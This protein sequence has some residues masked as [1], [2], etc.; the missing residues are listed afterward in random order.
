MCNFIIMNNTINLK[1]ACSIDPTVNSKMDRNLGDAFN[2]PLYKFFTKK[3][4]IRNSCYLNNIV[5][6][7]V[8]G[9]GSIINCNSVCDGDIVYGSGS[10]KEDHSVPINKKITFRSVRG[11][12]TRE[13]MLKYGYDCPPVYGDPGL[14][15]PFIYPLTPREKKYKIG[16]IPNYIDQDDT[17]LVKLK[18]HPDVLIINILCINAPEKF[19][20]DVNSCEY[21]FSSSL[22]GIIFGDAY[23]IPSYYMPLSDKVIGNGFKFKD[24]FLSV[25]RDFHII[26]IDNQSTIES[27]LSQVIPYKATIDIREMLDNFPFIDDDVHNECI[28]KLDT[29]F[30]KHLQ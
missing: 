1:F 15:M 7:G 22:H 25:S 19:V 13:K 21:I 2:I 6:N 29:G 4:V 30:M 11:P 9:M 17:K 20:H 28:S 14:L 16:I 10:I 3:N 5:K 26:N 27:L 24:Y 8:L 23:G 12:L 18:K